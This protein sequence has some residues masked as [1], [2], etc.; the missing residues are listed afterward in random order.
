[1]R[2]CRRADVSYPL[3]SIAVIPC[4]CSILQLIASRLLLE[5]VL[6]IRIRGLQA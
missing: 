5:A 1:M 3:E 4:F 2:T 6:M